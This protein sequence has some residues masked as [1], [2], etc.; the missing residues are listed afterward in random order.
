MAH[1]G[2]AVDVAE[3]AK[4]VLAERQPGEDLD[5]ALQRIC[6]RAYGDGQGPTVYKAVSAALGLAARI[7]HGD[8]EAVLQQLADGHLGAGVHVNMNMKINVAGKT[9]HSLDELPP[10]MRERVE[11][12]LAEQGTSIPLGPLTP[13][14]GTEESGDS[15]GIITSAL[16][17]GAGQETISA[18]RTYQCQ[19]CGY[20]A[21]SP[22]QICPQ[23]SLEQKRSFWARLFGR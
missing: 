6:N 13:A 20:T 3:L 18:G 21:A 19:R 15:A 9:V 17:G 16:P 8:R 7:R 1:D 2:Q 22:F 14:A 23:C 12:A 10:E 5:T 11:R 4:A